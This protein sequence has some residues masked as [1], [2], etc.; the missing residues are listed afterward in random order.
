[1]PKVST[2]TVQE[3]S[4][5]MGTVSGRL[6]RST[7]QCAHSF[8][9]CNCPEGE[10]PTHVGSNSPLPATVRWLPCLRKPFW[11][12]C[13]RG[14]CQPACSCMLVLKDACSEPAAVLYTDAVAALRLAECRRL[15]A[16]HSA[17][18]QLRCSTIRDHGPKTALHLSSCEANEVD[19]RYII[20]FCTCGIC[21]HAICGVLCIYMTLELWKLCFLAWHPCSSP[22]QCARGIL[23]GHRPLS[24]IQPAC[25]LQNSDPTA[26]ALPGLA[27]QL[28]PCM[29]S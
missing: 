4:Y 12:R 28:W 2:K 11:P 25:S 9:C 21:V 6:G 7:S 15:Q 8:C 27:R 23:V 22:P 19:Q 26:K 10:E 14:T 1:M 16:Q 18:C 29:E 3:C 13:L 20:N 5:K 24:S 17:L